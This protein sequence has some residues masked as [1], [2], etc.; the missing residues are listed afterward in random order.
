MIVLRTP[1]TVRRDGVSLLA[2]RSL[3]AAPPLLVT[4]TTAY[5]SPAARQAVLVSGP[6]LSLILAL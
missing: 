1:T 3:P 4:I 6:L 2:P 5:S